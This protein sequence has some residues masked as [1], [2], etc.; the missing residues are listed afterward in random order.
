[1]RSLLVLIALARVASADPSVG[2][3]VGAGA[4][5]DATYNALDVRFDAAWPSVRLGLGMRGEWDDGVFRQSDWASTGDLVTI[6]R[7]FEIAHGPFALAAGRLAPARVGH[8]VDGYRAVLDD[9]WRT[10]LRARVASETVDA[11]AEIDDVIDPAVIAA[12]ARWQFS[13]PWAA[14]A[15]AAIDPGVASAIE[16]GGAYRWQLERARIDAGG[17]VV[18][19]LGVGAVGFAEGAA[20]REGVRWSARAD[21]RAGTGATGSLFGP[22][23][24]LER[25]TVPARARRGELAGVGGGVAIGAAA[26][27]GWFELGARERPGL[28]PLVSAS[29]GAPMSRTWQAAAW[30]AAGSDGAAGAGELRV[31]WA[32][33]LYSALAIARMYREDRMMTLPAWSIVAWF[34]ATSE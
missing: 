16:A 28:G 9:R 21:V 15:T 27:A 24:R 20:D 23:Y 31:A 34:G 12:G 7:D 13:G 5:G 10:G 33:R 14:H 1:V 2:A 18:T 6:V 32:R 30:L 11:D 26:P 29:A 19:D 8:V 3:A 22:L 25:W 17:S 4:Q